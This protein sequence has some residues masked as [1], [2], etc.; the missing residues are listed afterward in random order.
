VDAF[1]RVQVR[2][3]GGGAEVWL[4]YQQSLQPCQVSCAECKDEAKH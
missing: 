3:I 4:G 2:S 1:A